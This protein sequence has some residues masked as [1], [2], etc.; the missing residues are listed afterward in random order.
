MHQETTFFETGS[1]FANSDQWREIPMWCAALVIA[2]GL[3]ALIGWC[4]DIDA[5]KSFLS[6]GVP[7]TVNTAHLLIL[8]GLCVALLHSGYLRAA[9]ILLVVSLLFAVA[10]IYENIS[11]ADLYIDR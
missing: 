10:I 4:F 2:A 3:T 7:M 8:G 11:G 1:K 6:D 9:R 5:F